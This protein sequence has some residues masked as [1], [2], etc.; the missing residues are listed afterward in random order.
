MWLADRW[1]RGWHLSVD[2]LAWQDGVLPLQ[3]GRLGGRPL[4]L[5]SGQTEAP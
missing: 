1:V 2:L 4:G 5:R 3:G